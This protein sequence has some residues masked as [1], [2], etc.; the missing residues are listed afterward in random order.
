LWSAKGLAEFGWRGRI[1]RLGKASVATIRCY[2]H[3]LERI[4]LP[5]LL[6]LGDENQSGF[7]PVLIHSSIAWAAVPQSV[8]WLN[9]LV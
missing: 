5:P 7:G 2:N 4:S 1:S 3:G 8:F 6:S 9:R